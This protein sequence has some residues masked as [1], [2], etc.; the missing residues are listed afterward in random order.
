MAVTSFVHHLNLQGRDTLAGWWFGPWLTAVP[1][2]RP[3]HVPFKKDHVLNRTNDFYLC[4]MGCIVFWKRTK[5]LCLLRPPPPSL[6]TPRVY[7]LISSEWSV[8]FKD[9]NYTREQPKDTGV[10][11]RYTQ[12]SVF[13]CWW[14]Q[15]SGVYSCRWPKARHHVM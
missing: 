4:E 15:L 6:P 12:R 14:S 9:C 1:I 3:L 7:W 2:N 5:C 10:S 11:V 13:V 8:I